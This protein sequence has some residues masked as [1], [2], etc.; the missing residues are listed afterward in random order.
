MQIKNRSLAATVIAVA[1]FAATVTYV[2]TKQDSATYLSN[3][4][5]DPTTVLGVAQLIGSNAEPC[6]PGSITQDFGDLGSIYTETGSCTGWIQSVEATP[7][8]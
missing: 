6:R 5:G 1:V 8:Y 3:R 2:L 4:Y 7:A